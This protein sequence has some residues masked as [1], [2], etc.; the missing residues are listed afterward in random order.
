MPDPQP[1]ADQVA[2]TVKMMGHYKQQRDNL[3]IQVA[4]LDSRLRTVRDENQQLT[5]RVAELEA[6]A[7]PPGQPAKPA[8]R[9]EA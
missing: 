6:A 8:K 1:S 7:A 4:A 3:E 9:K 5:A 2:L